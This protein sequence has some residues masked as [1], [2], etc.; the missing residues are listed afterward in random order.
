M[1]VGALKGTSAHHR[2]YF[3]NAL[4][5]L[6]DL[7]CR[8]LG[9][10]RHVVEYEGYAVSMLQG[11]GRGG[12]DL[13]LLHGLGDRS[14]TWALMLRRLSRGPWG[15]ILVPDLPGFGYSFVPEADVKRL[16]LDDGARF[17]RLLIKNTCADGAFVVGNS[18]GGWIACLSLRQAPDEVLGALLLAPAG[19]MSPEELGQAGDLFAH[20]DAKI[21]AQACLPDAPFIVRRVA[22]RMMAPVLESDVVQS[23]VRSDSRKHLFE[24]GDFAG[25]EHRLRILWGLQDGILPQSCLQR[26]QDELGDRVVTEDSLGHAPQRTRPDLVLRE[27]ERLRQQV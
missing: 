26:M 25:L 12:P 19:F 27:L 22:R 2:A 23:F 16:N 13:V 3:S 18:L 4:E 5:P 1:G 10:R 14:S 9:F 11:Q 6:Y 15:K 20:P 8:S 7:G 17:L 21:F 24:S